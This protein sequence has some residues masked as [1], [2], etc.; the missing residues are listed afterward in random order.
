MFFIFNRSTLL[1]WKLNVL[2]LF[3]FFFVDQK[4]L[5][6]NSNILENLKIIMKAAMHHKRDF[7]F[8]TN[9]KTNK[10]FWCLAMLYI[11]ADKQ[12]DPTANKQKYNT[13]TSLW[14]HESVNINENCNKTRYLFKASFDNMKN[15]NANIVF[16]VKIALENRRQNKLKCQKRKFGDKNSNTKKTTLKK[17]T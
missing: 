5:I 2:I 9:T 8:N 11:I 12:K 1:V 15:S 14:C 4:L 16:I 7:V 17:I 10:I 13:F 3:H 6:K